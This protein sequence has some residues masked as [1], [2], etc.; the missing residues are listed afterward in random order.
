MTKSTTSPRSSPR[1][2]K[3]DVC[4]HQ[5]RP[6]TV[7]LVLS[8]SDKST[9]RGR[10]QF[11]I[12]TGPAPV[13]S[14]DGEAIVF[15]RVEQGLATITTVANVP[16]FRP[17]QRVAVMNDLASAFGDGRAQSAR[18]VW[19]KPLAPVVIVACGTL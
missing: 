15:G 4:S 16:T 14:L 3:H 19:S 10:S 8:D 11:L 12:T 17:P 18:A 5:Q 9:Q 13:P 6:G 7:S 1:F 2:L